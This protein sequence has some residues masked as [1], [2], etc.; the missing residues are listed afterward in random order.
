MPWDTVVFLTITTVGFGFSLQRLSHPQSVQ[1]VPF[2]EESAALIQ[3]G[4][5]F[6]GVFDL[7]CLDSEGAKQRITNPESTIRMRGKFCRLSSK[8]MHAFDGVT[9][10]NLTNGFEGTIFF[11]GFNSAFT[12]DYVVLVPGKNIIQLEWRE[13]AKAE[14][15]TYIAEVFQR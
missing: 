13:S 4:S 12:T 10:K 9:V 3:Q 14:P 6:R 5:E 1:A 7:G 15:R 11:R 2:Q 8:D